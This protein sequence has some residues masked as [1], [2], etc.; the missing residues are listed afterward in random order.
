VE[1]DRTI[2]EAHTTLGNRWAEI[3]KM[4]PG[5]YVYSVL[6]ILIMCYDVLIVVIATSICSHTK[7]THT[8]KHITHSYQTEPTMPSRITGTPP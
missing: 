8:H 4:L 1:E 3:A 2:L 7:H 6:L 5:R